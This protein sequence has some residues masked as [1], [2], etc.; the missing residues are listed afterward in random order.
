MMY[1][2]DERKLTITVSVCTVRRA[3]NVEGHRPL[4][5]KLT[6][7][8]IAFVHANISSEKLLAAYESAPDAY[9][10]D[11]QDH[12]ACKMV[13]DAFHAMTHDIVKGMELS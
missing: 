3:V 12:Q 11:N 7:E 1:H 5:R 9:D 10:D 8:E 13:E 6:D 4:G 2:W